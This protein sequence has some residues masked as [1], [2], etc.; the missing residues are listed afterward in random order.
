MVSTKSAGSL[1][2]LSSLVGTGAAV[3]SVIPGVGTAIGGTAGA[4]LGLF[5]SGKS[6][7]PGPYNYD[8]TTGGCVPKPGSFTVSTTPTSSAC[9]P[10]SSYDP[11]TGNCKVGGI[12]G[13]VQRTLPGGATGYVDQQ[14]TP[15][16]AYGMQ[17]FVPMTIPQ[18]R[19][20]CPAGY[21][22][23]GKQPGMEVCLPKGFLANK[24]RKWPKSPNPALSAQDM[25]TLN[26]I[27]TLQNKIKRV[28]NT[29]GFTTK[30]R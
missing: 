4:I 7:C 21:V 29:A 2:S 10:G 27:R 18:T 28:A 23:Y 25:R 13:V 6:K 26:R 12:T 16:M 20:Q 14:Y 9:P 11:A 17:G 24:H 3:G 1:S 5:G 30:K 15:T 8:P 19:L 22:L